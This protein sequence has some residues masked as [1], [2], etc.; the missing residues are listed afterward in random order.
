MENNPRSIMTLSELPESHISYTIM[1]E[2]TGNI[3]Q[4]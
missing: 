1:R 3:P 4:N 2:N